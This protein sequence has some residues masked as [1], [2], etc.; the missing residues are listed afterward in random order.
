[1]KIFIKTTAR[2]GGILYLINIVFGIFAIAYVADTIIVQGNAA[3]TA[4]N[5]VS[6]EM[7]YRLGITAHIIILLTNVPWR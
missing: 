5:I 6:H 7:L 3:A 1:M 4:Q 2:I